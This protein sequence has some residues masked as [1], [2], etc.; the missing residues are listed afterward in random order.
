MTN[1][2]KVDWKFVLAFGATVTS[3]VFA[4]KMDGSAVERV[5]I[6]AIDACRDYAIAFHCDC[7]A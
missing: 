1:T 7:N 6:H 4:F 5:S 3:I 2:F